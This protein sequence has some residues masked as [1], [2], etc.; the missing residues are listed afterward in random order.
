MSQS[1]AESQANAP[2]GQPA[3]PANPGYA[4]PPPYGG[5]PQPP[6]AQ[7]QYPPAA[8]GNYPA[9]PPAQYPAPPAAPRTRAD[10]VPQPTPYTAYAGLQPAQA[11]PPQP[12]EVTPTFGPP[13]SNR[14]SS[15]L[16]I[17]ALLMSVAANVVATV[18]FL[19]VM[20][21]M[22]RVM[23]EART[24]P[25]ADTSWVYAEATKFSSAGLMLNI[26]FFV[27]LAAFIM[28]I[29]AAV[30]GRGRGWGVGTIVLSLLGP[31]ITVLI[32]TAVAISG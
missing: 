22:H 24:N 1:D 30:S 26:A 4:P 12:R 13:S 32:W 17:V 28:G 23:I 3:P 15:G 2:T 11:G 27:G 25:D 5:Y 29:V 8:P 19:P 10:G 16:G 18:G 21:L 6:Q 20:P 14:K 7:P 31:V 9:A